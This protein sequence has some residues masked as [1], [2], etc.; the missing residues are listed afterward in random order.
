MKRTAV[1]VLLLTVVLLVSG[2]TRTVTVT[3]KFRDIFGLYFVCDGTG[4]LFGHHLN[5]CRKGHFWRVTKAE[6]DQARVG[7]TYT[8]P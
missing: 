3:G 5:P 8:I 4:S 7:A 6:Y 1:A 2:C